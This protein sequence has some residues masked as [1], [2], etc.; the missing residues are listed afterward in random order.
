MSSVIVLSGE[1]A[2]FFVLTRA[3]SVSL[4]GETVFEAVG[5]GLDAGFDDI[6]VDAYCTPFFLAV[7]RFD[8]DP[9]P[10]ACSG[11]GIEDT[12][13]VVLQLDLFKLGKEFYQCSAERSVEC[14]YRAV[15]L[16]DGMFGHAVDLYFDARLDRKSTR[17]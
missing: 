9:G 13:F 1:T 17:L 3:I 16:G 5:Q 11:G 4:L 8:Q 12:H 2:E 6:V 7:S 15:A 10:G 14:V